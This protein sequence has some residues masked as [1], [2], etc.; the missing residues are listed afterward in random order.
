MASNVRVFPAMVMLMAP[1]F[2]PVLPAIA[3]GLPL[4][5]LGR[6]LFGI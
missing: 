1:L 5:I 4:A 2:A 3:P 6:L